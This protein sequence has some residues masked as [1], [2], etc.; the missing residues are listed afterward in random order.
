MATTQPLRNLSAAAHAVRVQSAPP[1]TRPRLS[2][3]ILLNIDSLAVADSGPFQLSVIGQFDL[4][5]VAQS[6]S[7]SIVFVYV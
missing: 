4:L 3:R 1:A 6:L 7:N 5:A 2:H